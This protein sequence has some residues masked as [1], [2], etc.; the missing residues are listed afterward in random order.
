MPTSLF[1]QNFPGV[2]TLQTEADVAEFIIGLDLHKKTIAICVIKSSQPYEPV[3]QRKR[4]KNEDLIRTLELFPGKK[5]V[6]CEAA[7]GWFPLRDALEGIQD[8]T[9]V[10]LDTRKTSSWVKASG[11]KSDKVDAEVLCHACLHGGIGCLAVH[12]PKRH[13]RDCCKL[14][15][16]REQLVREKTRLKN[17]LKALDRDYGV[18][19]YTGISAQMSEVGAYMKEELTVHLEE[20][21][22]KVLSAEKLIAQ[23]SKGD[24]VIRI[25]QSIPGVGPITSFLLRHKIEDIHR[26]RDPAHLSSYFGLSVRQRQSGDHIVKGKITKTGNTLMR[27]LLVQGAQVIRFRHPE[28]LPLYF[29][30]L[31]QEKLMGDPRHANK[32]AVALARKHLVFV[33]HIWKNG[34]LFNMNRYREKRQS[35]KSIAPSSQKKA[36]ELEFVFARAERQQV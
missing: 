24:T 1:K 5:L 25:L 6:A 9:F 23:L 15:H 2:E 19:P 22:Q 11:I 30:K 29:P 26:F 14:V 33:W 35:V 32:V 18:N 34:E 7:Y 28:Y 12:Q 36:A 27:K 20:I 13:A 16:Y 3:F 21:E 17:R 10:A 8:I 4:L 31:G